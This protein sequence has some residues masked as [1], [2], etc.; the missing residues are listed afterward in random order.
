MSDATNPFT[1]IRELLQE[2][3]DTDPVLGKLVDP[4]FTYGEG[5]TEEGTPTDKERSARTWMTVGLPEGPIDGF[6]SNNA[7]EFTRRFALSAATAEGELD[8]TALEAIELRVYQLL[9]TAQQTQLGQDGV[10]N[11][12]PTRGG[13]VHALLSEQLDDE[14]EAAEHSVIAF[15]GEV[16][17]KFVLTHQQIQNGE[18]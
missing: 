2:L 6:E 8:P 3:F 11:V 4:L 18:F 10:T 12:T 13:F 7:W 16:E 15:D 1:R 9:L 5:A 17:V 14:S